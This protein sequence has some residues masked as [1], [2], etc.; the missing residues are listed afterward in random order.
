LVFEQEHLVTVGH[1]CL[2]QRDELVHV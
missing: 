2:Y 1:P